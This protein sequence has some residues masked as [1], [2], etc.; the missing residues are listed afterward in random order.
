MFATDIFVL[1][2]SAQTSG[3]AWRVLRLWVNLTV[4]R[5]PTRRVAQIVLI[6]SGGHITR[7]GPHAWSLVEVLIKTLH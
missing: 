1:T 2:M 4:S 5:H 7:G 3:T 6:I